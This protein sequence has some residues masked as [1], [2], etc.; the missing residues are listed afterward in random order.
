MKN[1]QQGAR[2]AAAKMLNSREAPQRLGPIFS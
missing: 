2:E 1:T